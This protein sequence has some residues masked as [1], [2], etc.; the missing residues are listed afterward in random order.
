MSRLI[1]PVSRGV[2]F[3]PSREAHHLHFNCDTST[4]NYTN[5]QF[6]LVEIPPLDEQCKQIIRDVWYYCSKQLHRIKNPSDIT[7]TVKGERYWLSYDNG[8]VVHKKTRKEE[9]FHVKIWARPPTPYHLR[10]SI[11]NLKP[12]GDSIHALKTQPAN[13]K[14]WNRSFWV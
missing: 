14:K 12:T 9:D 11:I 13:I 10:W 3:T 6:R 7:V 8:Y 4:A 1:S 5:I 2:N